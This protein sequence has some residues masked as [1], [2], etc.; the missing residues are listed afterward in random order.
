MGDAKTFAIILGIVILIVGAVMLKAVKNS[1]YSPSQGSNQAGIDQNVDLTSE[2]QS[3]DSSDQYFNDMDS[4][5][6]QLNTDSS[7]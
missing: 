6:N 2:S 4:S 3:L 7:F 1:S 5:L